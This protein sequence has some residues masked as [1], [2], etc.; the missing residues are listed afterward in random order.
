MLVCLLAMLATTEGGAPARPSAFLAATKE[1][2]APARTFLDAAPKLELGLAALG[3]P[4]YINLGRDA[5]LGA[6]RTPAAMERRAHE[7]LDSAYSAGVHYFD[8][9]RARASA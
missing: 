3:R 4:G 6:D 8:C 9:A 2:G 5:E 7:V 1:G